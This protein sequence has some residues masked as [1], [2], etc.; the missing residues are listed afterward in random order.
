MDEEAIRLREVFRDIL[1]S[2]EKIWDTCLQVGDEKVY[3]HWQRINDHAQREFD[4]LD[5]QDR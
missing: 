1:R 5:Q 4:R 3:R 2:A